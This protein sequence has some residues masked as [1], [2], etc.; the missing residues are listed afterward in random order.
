MSYFF[1]NELKFDPEFMGRISFATYLAAMIGVLIYRTFLHSTSFT[2]I[3]VVSGILCVMVQMTI[4]L[5]VTRTNQWL[6]I[7]DGIFCFGDSFAIKV[8]AEINMMPVLVIACRLCPKNLE[9]TM[10]AAMMSVSNFGIMVSQ[11]LGSLLTK[12][13]GITETNFTNLWLLIIIASFSVILP[14]FLL[15][16][17]DLNRGFEAADEKPTPAE[18][19]ELNESSLSTRKSDE[20]MMIEMGLALDFKDNKGGISKV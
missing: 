2:K 4:L 13:L 10:Y 16:C 14:L 12:L 1:T 11:Q 3:F 15:L 8:L 19:Q 17:V 5:L 18:P 6:G 7:P 9:G 20:E